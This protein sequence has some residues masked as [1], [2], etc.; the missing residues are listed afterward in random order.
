[1]YNTIQGKE[2]SETLYEV[3]MEIHA[4]GLHN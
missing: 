3:I 2:S 1:V 4:S